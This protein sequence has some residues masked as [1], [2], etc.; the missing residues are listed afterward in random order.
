MNTKKILFFYPNT[1]NSPNIPNAIA[2]LAG[3]AKNFSWNMDY[4]D[5]YLYKKTQDSMEQRES[6]G[7]FKPSERSASIEFKP[8]DNLV[9]D[10]QRKIDIQEGYITGNEPLPTFT[11]DSILKMPQIS[12][13][14]IKNIR[15]V[16]LLY[17][18]L[19]ENYYPQI[20]K[21]EKDFHGNK[22]LYE[23]LVNIRWS[24]NS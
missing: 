16:F 19:P 22:E 10:L 9:L 15:K 20:E 14:E 12:S 1:A 13:E 3:I 6:S 21:C 23:E 11:S 17:A 8:L 5:T 18:T 4:F 7:E 24:I 2:I